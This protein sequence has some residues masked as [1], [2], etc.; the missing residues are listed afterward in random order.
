M[1]VWL[2]LCSLLF[3]TDAAAPFYSCT[4]NNHNVECGNGMGIP[5]TARKQV[6]VVPTVLKGLNNQR[7]R[8]VSDI[9]GAMLIGAAV[10]LP[11]RLAARRSCHFRFDCYQD[12]QP[13][14]HL[15]DVF[16]APATLKA[17][18]PHPSNLPNPGPKGNPSK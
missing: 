16:D 18:K 8:I 10:Q 2:I 9:V 13:L 1:R 5:C 4:C 3:A 14:L 12:Y 15:W 17:L 7:M 11:T 6:V